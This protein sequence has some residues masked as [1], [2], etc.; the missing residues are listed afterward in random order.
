MPEFPFKLGLKFQKN[1]PRDQ[2]LCFSGDLIFKNVIIPDKFS[3]KDKIEHIYDQG[4]LNSCT[5][6]AIAQQ[7]RITSDNKAEISRLFQY[8]NSRI[9]ED[10][11]WMDDGANLR[12]L[13]EN[14]I[15]FMKMNTHIMSQKFVKFHRRIYI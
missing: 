3:L 9:L 8:F 14:L 10:T 15:M 5:A 7:M 13:S 2:K 4:Q 12:E 1:D 6:N 11:Q